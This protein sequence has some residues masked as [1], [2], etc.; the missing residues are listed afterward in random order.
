[1]I[2][3]NYIEEGNLVQIKINNNW[4]VGKIYDTTTDGKTLWIETK[5]DIYKIPSSSNNIKPINS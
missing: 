4:E 1:M 5:E 3:Q 2:K